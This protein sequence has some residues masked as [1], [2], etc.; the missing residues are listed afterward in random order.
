MLSA[1]MSYQAGQTL[2]QNTIF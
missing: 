2:L 1:C